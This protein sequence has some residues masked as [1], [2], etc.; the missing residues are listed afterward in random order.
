[1]TSSIRFVYSGWNAQEAQRDMRAGRVRSLGRGIYLTTDAAR[2]DILANGLDVAAYRYPGSRL[3]GE[4][5]RLVTQGQSPIV[6]ADGHHVIFLE[7]DSVDCRRERPLLEDGHT[8]VRIE[9][10]LR[11]KA[12]QNPQVSR[13]NQRLV[14]NPMPGIGLYIDLPDPLQILLDAAHY[15][16]CAP[17]AEECLHLWEKLSPSKRKHLEQQEGFSESLLQWKRI[18]ENPDAIPIALPPRNRVRVYLQDIPWGMM[19]QND[20][21]WTWEQPAQVPHCPLPE[22]HVQGLLQ[23]LMPENPDQML[24]LGIKE[25]QD[26]RAFLKEPRRLMNFL[27]VPDPYTEKVTPI[28]NGI[29][30]GG[31]L[32][33]HT[34]RG[35][36]Q[37][38][39]ADPFFDYSQ[40][41]TRINSSS[42]FP[43]ISG[44]QPKM[45]AY[46]D[47]EGRLQFA[48]EDIPFTLLV[49]PDPGSVLPKLR[50][51]AMLEWASQQVTRYV[52]I[53]TPE[54]AL[55]IAPDGQQAALISERFDVPHFGEYDRVHLTCDGTALLGIP[56]S[57]KYEANPR[58]LWQAIAQSI[59]DEDQQRQAALDY[60]DRLALAW[61]MCDGD[62]HAKNLSVLYT[63]QYDNEGRLGLWHGA[64]S[65]AYDTICTRALPGFEHDQQALRIEGHEENLSPK[66]WDQFGKS[67]HIPNG[68][69]RAAHISAL[70]ADAYARM[71]NDPWLTNQ[72]DGDYQKEV[73][74]L[75]EKSA[76]FTYER[77]RYMGGDLREAMEWREKRN[78][79][80]AKPMDPN[81]DQRLASASL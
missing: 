63:S 77:N 65:P 4:S 17:S 15:P 59:P 51:M 66:I 45:P 22:G 55:L 69:Q 41:V 7:S 70:V 61:A 62:A 48:T 54:C 8:G 19:D 26:E 5:A 49:K 72:I 56:A 6:F 16:E 67:M 73:A 36:F 12:S 11:P 53:R 78:S 20:I 24:G 38:S 57:R 18:M 74:L 10:I 60:F 25:Q 27:F 68:G 79:E 76:M 33:T 52:G 35:I 47:K 44:M 80:R 46:L 9:A 30:Q 64:M 21:G 71:A 32:N 3:M 13:S 39:I 14:L 50:G 1:M 37:G 28:F 29:P 23:S 42:R 75:L 31:D 81:T 43:R 58:L 34:Q 2:R 40:S